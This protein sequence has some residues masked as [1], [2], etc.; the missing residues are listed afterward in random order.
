MFINHLVKI[1]RDGN[2]T[3]NRLTH[4]ASPGNPQK[5]AI[6]SSQHILHQRI[7]VDHMCTNFPAAIRTI[8]L[9][10]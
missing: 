9:D 4:I 10:V 3:R 6:P 8:R 7:N 5:T 1:P 2:Q